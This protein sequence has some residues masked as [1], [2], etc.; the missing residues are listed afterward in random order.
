MAMKKTLSAMTE[1]LVVVICTIAF[2][3]TAV[4]ILASVLGRGAAGNRDFVEYWASGYLLVHHANPYDAHLILPLEQAQNFPPGVPVLVM[5]NPPWSLP[6]MA[7]LGLLGPKTAELLWIALSLACLIASVRMVWRLHGSPKSSLNVLGY[8]FAPALSCLFSGQV[9]I[10]VLF[11]LVLFLRLQ[12]TRPFLAGASLWLCML[13]PHLFLPFGIVLLLW[14]VL[15]RSY[16]ILVG[17]VVALCASTIIAVALDPMMWEHYS[18]MMRTERIDLRPIPC[19]SVVL[20]QIL[21]PHTSAVQFLPI[22]VGCIWA[23]VYFRRHRSEWNWLE[24]GSL[25]MLV[26]V[27]LAPYTWL[28]DQTVLLPALLHGI[29]AT[30]SRNLVAVLGL[31]SAVVE[32]GVLLGLSLLHSNFY[33][34]TSPVW[35]LWY[36]LATHIGGVMRWNQPPP[37]DQGTAMMVENA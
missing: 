17:T 10:F 2:A 20:R 26:S 3:L 24:H 15:T 7:P 30:R 22:V 18:Q 5:G 19:L 35:L 37:R 21:W 6:L 33:L 23:L 1:S 12:R 14:V 27:L 31:A 25:L 8:T 32:I 4:G 9:T 11:G 36:L 34:W 28:M 29:Y 13:K 16:R